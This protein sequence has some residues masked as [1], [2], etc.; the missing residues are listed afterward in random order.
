MKA[1][2]GY[3]FDNIL[4][5]LAF[6]LYFHSIHLFLIRAHFK[7]AK[8]RIVISQRN[9]RNLI[10]VLWEFIVIVCEKQIRT[11]WSLKR[12]SLKT[13]AMA[14]LC[15]QLKK[16][17]LLDVTVRFWNKQIAFLK[18]ATSPKFNFANICSGF[19]NIS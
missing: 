13:V 18:Y 11:T 17:Q 2:S 7:S 16:L 3:E 1:C 10:G 19:N 6:S 9:H 5:I 15:L 14:S 8:G 12:E 4:G